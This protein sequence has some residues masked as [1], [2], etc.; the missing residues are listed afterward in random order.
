LANF[1]EIVRE[2]DAAGFAAT[3]RVNLRLDN[4]YFRAEGLRL[5]DCLIDRE[6]RAAVGNVDAVAAQDC[7]ALI[8]VYVQNINSPKSFAILQHVDGLT[9]GRARRLERKTSVDSFGG[10]AVLRGVNNDFD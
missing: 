3:A 4:G 7:L 10:D 1:V 6:S 8:F 2:F 5:L 9:F